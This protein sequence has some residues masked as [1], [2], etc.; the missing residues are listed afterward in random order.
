MHSTAWSSGGKYACLMSIKA[1]LGPRVQMT[2]RLP[3]YILHW[4][5]ICSFFH[6]SG[7]QRKRG[8]SVGVSWLDLEPEHLFL[9]RF[10]QLLL[11]QT[12]R[13]PMKLLLEKS[14]LHWEV[15]NQM[16]TWKKSC[17]IF[18]FIF[19]LS[20]RMTKSSKTRKNKIKEIKV[21]KWKFKQWL[22]T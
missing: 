22:N 16:K 20:C 15:S 1:R 2:H 11:T 10:R 13:H 12:T 8:L 7:Y 19:L 18:V 17:G 21:N 6:H 5:Y 4:C 9:T 3:I 14:K